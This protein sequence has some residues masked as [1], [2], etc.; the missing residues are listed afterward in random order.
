[1]TRR[2][3]IRMILAIIEIAVIFGV[4]LWVLGI[5][6]SFGLAEEGEVWVMCR[7]GSEVMIR[8]GPGRRKPVAGVVNCGDMLIT[9]GKAR[10]GWIHVV[11]LASETGEGWISE[12]YVVFDEMYR[13]DSEGVITGRGRVACRDSLDGKRTGW[14]MPG[15]VVE[16]Y[17]VSEGWAVTDRGYISKRYLEVP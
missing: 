1:M 2:D 7:P 12:K 5:F 9:D 17:W 16:V 6:A 13:I 11:G 15:D 4:T 8:E 3:I 10:G 14:L